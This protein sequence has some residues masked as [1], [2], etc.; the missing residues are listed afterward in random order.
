M[1]KKY[2]EDG[3]TCQITFSLP[4]QVKAKKAHLYG[5][6]TDWEKSPKE[7]LPQED[8]GFSITFLLA[9]GHHYLDRYLLGG[10]PWENDWA[11]DAYEPN[12]FGTEDS[13]LQ[14]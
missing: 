1:I 4:A 12:P 6:F 8:G 5:G 14:L 10:Q 2:A 9:T 3:K 11:A 7:M 13:V